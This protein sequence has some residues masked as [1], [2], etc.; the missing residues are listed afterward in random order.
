MH[1]AGDLAVALDEVKNDVV[2]ARTTKRTVLF[3]F[4]VVFYK[5]VSC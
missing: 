1:L 2:W 3:L 4:V 5:S